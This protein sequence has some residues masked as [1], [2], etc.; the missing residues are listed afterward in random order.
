MC[1]SFTEHPRPL[2]MTKEVSSSCRSPRKSIRT[3]L[4]DCIYLEL[5]I[6]WPMDNKR[7]LARLLSSMYKNSLST[8]KMTGKPY[9]QEWVC[10]QQQQQSCVHWSVPVQ[11][12]L[13]IHYS[14]IWTMYP[15]CWGAN[16]T[17][18]RIPIQAHQR[19]LSGK[20]LNVQAIWQRFKHHA[21]MEYGQASMAEQ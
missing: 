7:L 17:D 10:V 16:Q 13:R 5:A 20:R 8:T 3:F 11:G 21:T 12:K 2:C 18:W 14:I 6:W 1:G 15:N 9:F 19:S 4:Y